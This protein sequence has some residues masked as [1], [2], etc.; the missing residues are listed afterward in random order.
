MNHRVSIDE[1]AELSLL[2]G[3]KQADL[4]W[5]LNQ[6]E[7]IHMKKN[8]VLLSPDQD[9][10]TIYILLD[11]RLIVQFSQQ[12]GGIQTYVERGGWVGEMSVIDNMRP[13]ATV[14][15][16][17]DVKLLA[18]HASVW[19]NLIERSHVAARN[20]LRAVSFRLREDNKLITE[21]MEKQ[22]VF[23]EK[24]QTDSLTGL[25]NRHWLEEK[26]PEIMREQAVGYPPS[27]IIMLDID[28]FKQFNDQYGHL[29]GDS[30][31]QRVANVIRDNLRE[32][33]AAVRYG[34]EELILVLPDTSS[35]NAE[36][37]AQRLRM[38]IRENKIETC[39]GEALPAVSVSIGIYT[40][41][42]DDTPEKIFSRV[43]AALYQAKKAGRD[44]V[45]IWGAA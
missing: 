32:H 40:I 8:R 1:L 5:L 19:W 30:V 29:A 43:D 6:C 22:R 27:S 33:D 45:V 41:C 21:G 28:H 12:Q 24:A 20:F 7:L 13:S 15:T 26:L 11:G 4:N 17:T 31:L 14:I 23:S 3:V 38:L 25:R 37:I 34:G 18:I 39:N 10:E 2:R 16:D 35:Q 9:N 36:Q 42:Q 44:R